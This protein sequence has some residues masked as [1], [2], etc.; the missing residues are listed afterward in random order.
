M[1]HDWK[2]EIAT[3]HHADWL[4]ASL[5]VGITS[6]PSLWNPF[7]VHQT[8]V[9]LHL[10]SHNLCLD[11]YIMVAELIANQCKIHAASLGG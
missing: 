9:T 10:A 11:R 6:I 2:T 8:M 3:V 1:S 7:H 4:L 5:A